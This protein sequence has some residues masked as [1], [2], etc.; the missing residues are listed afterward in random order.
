VS[1]VAVNKDIKKFLWA[2]V[3]LVLAYQFVHFVEYFYNLPEYYHDK[4]SVPRTLVFVDVKP[5]DCEFLSAPMGEKHCH[6]DRKVVVITP[7][8]P[9]GIEKKSVYVSWER[10]EE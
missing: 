9:A 1:A 2:V 7:D 5:H 10:V 6:Y 8:P 4:Y 3:L